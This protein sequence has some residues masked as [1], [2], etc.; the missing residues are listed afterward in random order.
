MLIELE[1]EF[2]KQSKALKHLF[3]L[4]LSQQRLI[5]AQSNFLKS[6]IWWIISSS[7]TFRHFAYINT[8]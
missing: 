7:R 1:R 6:T 2:S 3:E 8:T 4:L 5:L